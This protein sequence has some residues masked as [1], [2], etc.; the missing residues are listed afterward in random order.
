MPPGRGVPQVAMAVTTHAPDPPLFRN[1]QGGPVVQEEPPLQKKLCRDKP[2][3]RQ[4]HTG[5]HTH[6]KAQPCYLMLRVDCPRCLLLTTTPLASTLPLSPEASTNLSLASH[7]CKNPHGRHTDAPRSCPRLQ[8]CLKAAVV[9]AVTRSQSFI[10]LPKES[11]K[12]SGI[13]RPCWMTHFERKGGMVGSYFVG[14]YNSCAQHLY[15]LQGTVLYSAQYC[16]ILC[17]LALY[18]TAQYL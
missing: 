8:P 15:L 12:V 9:A 14:L 1:N 16:A 2:P 13:S 17:N 11:A 3:P 18:C 6:P 7:R 5:V 10:R 4:R